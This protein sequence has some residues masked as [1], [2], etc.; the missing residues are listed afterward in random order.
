MRTWIML[1]LA[2][3]LT[4][5]AQAQIFT[6]VTG[7]PLTDTPVSYRSA[8][9]V[10][11]DNDGYA[12]AFVTTGDNNT[13][14][15]LFM[16]NQDGTF[17]R[18]TTGPIVNEHSNSDGATFGDFNNDGYL[19]C[20]VAN[21]YN[22][23]NLLY[24]AD[25]SGGWTSRTDL[26]PGIDRGYSEAASW[27]DIDNDGDLD[28][29]VANSEGDFKNFLYAN[30]GDGTFT[31]ILTGPVA[32]DAVPSRHGAWGDYDND[33]D[34]D[35]FV[36]S[37]N[38]HVNNLYEN[39]GGGAFTKITTGEVVTDSYNSWS[40]SWGDYDN[41]GDL[42]LFV[43]NSAGQENLL[44][45]NNGDKTF[46]RVYPLHVATQS[47]WS[48]SAAWADV[49]NDGDLDLHVANGYH[50]VSATGHKNFLYLN[51][52]AGNF[53]VDSTDASVSDV[54]WSYGCSFADY[55]RDGDQ[56]L[57]VARW[58]FDSET[59]KLYRNNTPAGNGWISVKCIGTVSNNAA[60]G[61]RLRLKATISGNPVWQTHEIASTSGYC[62]Q[63]SLEAEFGLGNAAIID[64]LVIGWPSGLVE[65][66]TD[67]A[68][69]Q[70]VTAVEGDGSLC[71]GR[72]SDRDGFTDPDDL[73]AT[74][75]PDNCPTVHN[76]DQADIDSDG[77]GDPCDACPNDFA[78]DGDSDGLCA[79]L[80][81][82]PAVANVDQADTDSDGLGDA[83]CCL[84]RGNVDSSVN[85][86]VNVSDLTYLVN[87][88]FKSGPTP[89]CPSQAN[90]DGSAN[91]SV[92]VSDLT[93]LVNFLFKSGPQPPACSS[94]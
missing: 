40:G 82:C 24:E 73:S 70:Y 28:L 68:I 2:T 3:S 44:Y 37:E 11:V 60:I 83:C 92:N 51:D 33:G 66:F 7:Q 9:F 86:S 64:S 62:G 19:D 14:N 41:D 93:Y 85:G 1:L 56:D 12:D 72:D 59:N 80:D 89:G 74:C 43:A 30:N 16:N 57:L 23:F 78:N 55:D 8:N 77:I 38:G 20:A 75:A 17:T 29:F 54:G 76:R 6:K 13:N 34:Q 27:A 65:Y 90:V 48:T 21:W 35:L 25:G 47:S 46:T 63:A 5:T 4:A 91:G 58:Q 50:P 88:L 71:S 52:G 22:Q 45:E 31:R 84:N 36:A 15:M 87:R 94:V 67:V 79:D 18:V 69:N 81:N 10:D 61:A 42:D 39:N 53:T 32:T 49:D 26:Q